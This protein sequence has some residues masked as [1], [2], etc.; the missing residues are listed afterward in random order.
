[1]TETKEK[2]KARTKR[3]REKKPVDRATQLIDDLL[4][5]YKTPQE[6][7]GG[8]GLLGELTRRLVERASQGELTNP[9]GYDK[10]RVSGRNSGNSRNG[11]T[12][13]TIQTQH[14]DQEVRIPRDRNGT[15]EPILLPKR[16][17]RL[18]NFDDQII[19]L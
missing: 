13:K 14:G 5:D 18:G 8:E 19:S 2:A 17:R 4:K 7:L 9:L 11:S 12:A 15:Y 16:E 3:L 1:M 10:H 6:I